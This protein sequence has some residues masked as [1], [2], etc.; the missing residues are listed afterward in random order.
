MRKEKLKCGTVV[1]DSAT[2]ELK[3]VTQKTKQGIKCVW[4]DKNNQLH[5]QIIDCSKL[6][7]IPS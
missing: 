1:Y 3:T 6:E 2:K 4:F 7:P 5:R